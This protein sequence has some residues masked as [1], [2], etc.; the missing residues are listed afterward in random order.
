MKV[1][2]LIASLPEST[3]L[4]KAASISTRGSRFSL[5]T[6]GRACGTTRTSAP[7]SSDTQSQG[8]DQADRHGSV[9]PEGIL[10]GKHVRLVRTRST[11]GSTRLMARKTRLHVAHRLSKV[12]TGRAGPRQ[13][14]PCRPIFALLLRDHFA[15]RL[16]PKINKEVTAIGSLKTRAGV[17]RASS[18]QEAPGSWQLARTARRSLCRSPGRPLP[19]RRQ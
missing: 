17:S 11:G 3:S 5:S 8:P 15:M 1:E 12:P 4:L 18:A 7:G 10:P 16:T 19:P 13:P 14:G 2:T 6:S 9:H